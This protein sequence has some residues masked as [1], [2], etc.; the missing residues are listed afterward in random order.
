MYKCDKYATKVNIELE[1][2]LYVFDDESATGKTRLCKLF[3]ELQRLDEPVIGYTFNDDKLGIDLV[4]Q[5]NVKKP[6]VLVLD[7]Y[8]MYKGTFDNY[9]TSWSKNMI[10][11]IDC[12][13]SLDINCVADWCCIEMKADEIEVL[14]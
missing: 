6:Q 14:Q 13:G 2:G 4:S 7:R 10:V 9:F 3:K 1:N 5:I 8:D 12:K 11:L